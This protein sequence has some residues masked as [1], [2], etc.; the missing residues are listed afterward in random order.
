[1][2]KISERLVDFIGAQVFIEGTFPIPVQGGQVAYAP[3]RGKLVAVFD[4]G[5]EIVENGEDVGTVYVLANIRSVTL[6]K[7]SKIVKPASGRI[8]TPNS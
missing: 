8:I 5:F 2:A 6:L 4:E 3:A 1:V 7:E